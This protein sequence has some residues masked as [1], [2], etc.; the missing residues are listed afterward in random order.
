MSRIS[1][2]LF[3]FAIHI[4]VNMSKFDFYYRSKILHINDPIAGHNE[5]NVWAI[6]NVED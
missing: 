5:G 6:F 2:M 4:N 1:E 3:T